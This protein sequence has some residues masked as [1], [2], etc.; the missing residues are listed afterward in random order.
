MA[1]L[2]SDLTV[3]RLAKLSERY[4]VE[5]T[6]GMGGFVCEWDPNSPTDDLTKKE[7][8]AYLKCRDAVIEEFSRIIGGAIVLVEPLRGAGRVSVFG[9]GA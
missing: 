5:I 4:S 7:R 1:V 9:D 3:R 6:L 2:K 8:R